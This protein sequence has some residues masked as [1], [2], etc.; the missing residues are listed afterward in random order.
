MSNDGMSVQIIGSLSGMM[1]AGKD[2]VDLSTK[3]LAMESYACIKKGAPKD[4]GQLVGGFTFQKEGLDYHIRN[5]VEHSVTMNDG[6]PPH[7]PPWAAI[8]AWAARKNLPTFP[9][10]YAICKHG[11]KARHYVE[12]GLEQAKTRAP[13]FMERAMKE[14]LPKVE[15]MGAGK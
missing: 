11:I 4:T 14:T 15:A 13:E 1:N 9:I 7:V 2:V 10:W 6:A 5:A 12:K 3:Y 8:D